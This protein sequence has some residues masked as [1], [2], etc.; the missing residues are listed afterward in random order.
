MVLP[1]LDNITGKLMA[2][3]RRMFSYIIMNT[4]VLFAKDGALVG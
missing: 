1:Y 2:H 4:F 3:N